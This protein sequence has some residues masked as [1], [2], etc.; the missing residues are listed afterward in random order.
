M[1]EPKQSDA[2]MIDPPDMH[3]L[4]VSSLILVVVLLSP[5][6]ALAFLRVQKSCAMRKSTVT[7]RASTT[8]TLDSIQSV[9]GI[10][11]DVDGTLADSWK[12]GFDAT[13][14]V[15]QNHGIAPIT[16]DIYHDHTRYCTPDRLARHAGFRPEDGPQFEIV[17]QRLG[18]EF[19]NLYVNLVSKESAGFYSGIPSLLESIPS[20]I[21]LGLL[22]N[23]C[24]AYAEAVLR[25][26]N[27]NKRFLSVHG[28]DSIPAPKPNPDGL[29]VCCQEMGLEP[30][31]CVYIGDSPSDA[32]AAHAAG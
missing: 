3:R 27:N 23:A 8:R 28:A 13:Q 25:V 5:T 19:D 32:M 29:L 9:K 6:V 22:T 12:L 10:L 11:F 2:S 26:N 18:N 4:Y 7:A 20:R 14:V 17:G 15:L 24:V 21:K 30:S 1:K 31:S 16:E